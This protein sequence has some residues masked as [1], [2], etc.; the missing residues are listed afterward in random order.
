MI[1]TL[2]CTGSDIDQIEGLMLKVEFDNN[3]LYVN[4]DSLR[5]FFRFVSFLFGIK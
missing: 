2:Y 3:F 1:D 4:R 5:P